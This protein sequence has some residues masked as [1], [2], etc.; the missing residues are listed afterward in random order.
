MSTW[1][2]LATLGGLL[3]MGTLTT[4]CG[5]LSAA[6]NPKV[7][8]AIND[9]APMS[10]VVRR[11]DA[12]ESTS[13]EVDRLLTQTPV[14]DKS[15]WPAETSPTPEEAT[16]SNAKLAEHPLYKDSHARVVPA[17]VWSKKLASIKPDASGATVAAA[18]PASAKGQKPKADAK[19]DPKMAKKMG[20]KSAPAATAATAAK[21]TP[22]SAGPSKA[23]IIAAIDS[24]LGDKY[25]AIMTKKRDIGTMKTQIASEKTAADEKGVSAA[26][27]KAHEDRIKELEKNV[28]TAEKEVGGMSKEFLASVTTA[29]KGTAPEVR[30]QVG[31]ALVNFRQAVAD[32]EISNGAAAVK[33]PLA[34]RGIPDSL[35]AMAL[36][37]ACDIVEEQTG[38]RPV[39]AGFKPDITFE[40]GTVGLTINGIAPSDLGKLSVADLTTQTTAR[41]QAWV[42]HTMSLLGSIAATEDVL[43]F[44]ADVLDA[45]TNGLSQSGWKAPAPATIGEGKGGGGGAASGGGNVGGQQKLSVPGLKM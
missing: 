45:I 23:S 13:K 16:D 9:P 38:K 30:E 39:L 17:E 35:K 1:M 41:L 14:S 18:T 42:I 29:A 15:T 37:Y 25:G 33:Y 12:A 36:V 19:L 27:K 2:K 21:T 8:W 20:A 24:D 7:A 5:A 43:E 10:V 28:E 3:V 4:G 32:A 11:A 26:D 44:E 40:D 34:V 31:Q 22:A 6:A